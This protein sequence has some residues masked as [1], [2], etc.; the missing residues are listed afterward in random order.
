MPA[1][2]LLIFSLF[3]AHLHALDNLPPPPGHRPAKAQPSPLRPGVSAGDV[4]VA[5]DRENDLEQDEYRAEADILEIYFEKIDAMNIRVTVTFA[6]AFPTTEEGDTYEL[7][8]YIDMDDNPSTGVANKRMGLDRLVGFRGDG[9]N[10]RWSGTQ[11]KYEETRDKPSFRLSNI[12]CNGNRVS[13]QIRSNEPDEFD[14]FCFYAG[15][16]I[17]NR[18]QD[19][20]QPT[21]GGIGKKAELTGATAPG[22]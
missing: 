18:F 10:G 6:G 15:S 17:N 3:V 20:L 8:M 5:V 2:V 1:I 16:R 14:E 7:F 11:T 22:R 21:R 12:R 9:S 4:F 19:Y 13:M